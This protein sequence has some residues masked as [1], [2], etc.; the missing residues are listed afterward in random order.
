MICQWRATDPREEKNGEFGR[1]VSGL[2]KKRQSLQILCRH[3]LY[4]LACACMTR[5]GYHGNARVLNQPST[6][7]ITAAQNLEYAGRKSLL[8][9]FA[10]LQSRV[11]RIG[12][13]LA[14]DHVTGNDCLENL[15][16][17]YS[18][19]QIPGANGT[20]DSNGEISSNRQDSFIVLED[21]LR[22]LEGHCCSKS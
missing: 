14:D 11:G 16:S 10:K 2:Q 13:I 4:L 3:F 12:A 9:D 5:K 17:H 22:D 6:H 18:N 7:I 19:W 21:F 20:D 15:D 8:S 1:E